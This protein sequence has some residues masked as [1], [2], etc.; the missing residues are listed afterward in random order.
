MYD[1]C[2]ASICDEGAWRYTKLQM[3]NWYQAETKWQENVAAWL[4]AEEEYESEAA[5]T[6]RKKEADAKL[7]EEL[8]SKERTRVRHVTREDQQE[9]SPH[10]TRVI[11]KQRSR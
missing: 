9:A 6:Y 11:A 8:R 5:V 2:G 10:V 7:R 4:T 3:G 1:C